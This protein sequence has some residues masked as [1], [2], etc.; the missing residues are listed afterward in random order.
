MSASEVIINEQALVD[1]ASSLQTYVS[2][3]K[4]ALETVIGS[5]KANAG[6]W[7]D[8][9]FESLVSAVT[10]FTEDVE[11][12]ENATN[13]IVARINNRINAIHALHNM[14]I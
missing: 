6:D 4:E 3:L 5:I 13:Q 8:E 1:T 2:S 14:K 12:V 9:D 7:N 11:S 10:S